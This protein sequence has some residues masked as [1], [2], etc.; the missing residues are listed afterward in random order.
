MAFTDWYVEGPSFGNCNCGYSC[1][2]QFEERP[3]HGDCRGFEVLEISKGHFGDVD[4]KGTKAALLYAW[5]GAIFEGKGEMQVIIDPGAS[6]AQRDALRR[7]FQGE[8]TEEEAT[9]W[10]VFRAMCDKVHDTLYLPIDLEANMEGRTAKVQVG[11]I[12]TS[13]GRPIQAPHGGGEHR[14][15]IDIPGGIEFSIAE[16]GSASTT[17]NAGIKLELKDS[18]GQWHFLKHGPSGVLH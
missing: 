12:L 6:D 18:F 10:W 14:V 1:P 3:T 5:P 17:A 9:H 11:D 8:E 2:C 4:L 7:V 13:T 15:R 16:I